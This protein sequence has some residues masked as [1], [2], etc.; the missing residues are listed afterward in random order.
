MDAVVMVDHIF[1]FLRHNTVLESQLSCRV[2]LCQ[3]ICQTYFLHH[4]QLHVFVLEKVQTVNILELKNL[5]RFLRNTRLAM[6]EDMV[7]ISESHREFILVKDIIK[8][9]L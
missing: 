3:V 6:A 9:Y 2:L 7:I 1:L 5:L 8:E 4:F